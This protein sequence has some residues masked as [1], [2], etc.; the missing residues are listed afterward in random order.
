LKH[1]FWLA[2]AIFL[3]FA[4]TMIFP[5]FTTQILSVRDPATAPRLF[6]PSSFIP[7][8]FLVWNIGDLIG[9]VIP[10]VPS[11]SL[12]S[13]PRTLFLLSISRILFI[14]LYLL[15]NLQGKGAKISSD[16]FY[17]FIVQLLFGVSNGYIGSNCMMGFVEYVNADERE[18][19]GGF[20]SLCLVA[21][22][23]V[24][25]FLSF[26]AAGSG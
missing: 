16:V 12:T 10:A 13:H 3:T 25:S 9:R 11:L 24:G 17:L 23:T 14:P 6:Q 7:L 18:A 22:L 1:L 21:G 20:M 2:G 19:A 5:V 4:I 26:F 15:C 8:A